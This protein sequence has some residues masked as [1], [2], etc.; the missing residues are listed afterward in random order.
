MQALI[1]DILAYSRISGPEKS[2]GKVECERILESVMQDLR[3]PLNESG[4]IVTHDPLPA[5]LA[6]ESQLGH[7][8]RNLV[9]N[10][11]KF[12]SK[13]RPRVH[14]GVERQEGYWRFFV[15]DNGIGIDSRYAKNLFKLFQ[16]LHGRNS[17]PGTGIGL[18]IAKRVI[19]RHGGQIWFD[20]QPDQ[21]STF[22]FTLP[23]HKKPQRA[24]ENADGPG[25]GT[26][27]A[28]DCITDGTPL[29]GIPR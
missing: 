17:Y 1:G 14:V 21:G 5:V 23:V 12:R 27:L 25:D 11:I 18:A 3:G 19:E 7:V 20:S 16:R 29:A 8:F 22:Y 6:E 2:L 15:R 28:S 10:A 24:D 26:E 9:G 4:A 13:D